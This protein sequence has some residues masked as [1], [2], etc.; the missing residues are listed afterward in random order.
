[1]P[2]SYEQNKKHIYKWRLTHSD[3]QKEL[4]RKHAKTAYTKECYYSY[5]RITKEF[6]RLQYL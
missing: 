3:K 4:S 6:R 5:D 2:L 1:M